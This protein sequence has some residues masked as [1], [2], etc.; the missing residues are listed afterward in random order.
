MGKTKRPA[1]GKVG[2]GAGH[3][4]KVR[5]AQCTTSISPEQLEDIKRQQA[6]PRDCPRFDRCSANICPLDADWGLR[7]HL[8][9]ER[10]CFYLTELVKPG[11]MVRIDTRLSSE[12]AEEVSNTHPAIVARF[13]EI[14][15]E[16]KRAA[17]RPP[18]LGRR[19]GLRKQKVA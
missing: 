15:Y 7:Q 8:K 4:A 19:V 18:R 5:E 12:L 11:G 10:I 9:G 17:K 1:E 14:R 13:C 2:E 3:D 16:L 6:E